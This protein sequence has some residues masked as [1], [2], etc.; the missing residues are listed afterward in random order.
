[1]LNVA[2]LM[3]YKPPAGYFDWTPHMGLEET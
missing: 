1:M 2:V 3:A